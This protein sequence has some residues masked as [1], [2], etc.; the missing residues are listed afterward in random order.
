MAGK[1]TCGV[2]VSFNGQV[3]KGKEPWNIRFR[4]WDDTSG[5]ASEDTLKRIYLGRQTW[6]GIPVWARAGHKIMLE[7]TY[8]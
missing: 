8:R 4:V 3:P 2:F 5:S 1:K 7:V 6:K